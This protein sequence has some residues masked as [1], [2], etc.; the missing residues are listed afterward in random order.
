MLYELRLRTVYDYTA[1]VSFAQNQ[2]RLVP[3]SRNRQRLLWHILSIDPPP[4]ERSESVDA[5]GNR[6]CYFVID[7]PHRRLEIELRGRVEVLGCV[8]HAAAA[9]A[10]AGPWEHLRDA[11]AAS[12]DLGSASPVHMLYPTHITAAAPALVELARSCFAPGREFL[13]A[14]EALVEALHRRL[15][16]VPGSTAVHTT[17]AEALAEGQGVCQDFAHIM[18]AAMRALS[19]P[20]AYVSGLLRTQPPP[21]KPRLEGADAM[22]AWVSVWA[23]PQAGWIDFDPTN[24]LRVDR[25]HIRIAVGRDYADAAPLDGVIVSGG[26]QSHE[27]MVDVVPV[28]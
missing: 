4:A 5:F 7:R 24:G 19:L 20:A 12:L 9:A 25:D 10:S 16:Y 27:V 1:P 28:R 26:A 11:A 15:R 21:G 14:V 2:I 22:H 3:E 8:S 13:P 23:G 6:R 17:A 18:V